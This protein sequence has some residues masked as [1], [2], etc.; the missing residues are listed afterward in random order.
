MTPQVAFPVTLD[1]VRFVDMWRSLDKPGRDFA[2]AVI[3]FAVAAGSEEF[4]RLRR[5]HKT[6]KNGRTLEQ[7]TKAIRS[8]SWR[9]EARRL[10]RR[11]ALKMVSR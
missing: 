1:E 2:D 6:V 4:R 3:D 9:D 11:R 5:W 10:E 7:L 8:G